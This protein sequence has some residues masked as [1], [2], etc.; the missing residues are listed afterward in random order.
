MAIIVHYCLPYMKCRLADKVLQFLPATMR[1]YLSDSVSDKSFKRP[2]HSKV[3]LTPCRKTTNSS[4]TGRGC[5]WRI[6]LGDDR[7]I[8]Q[9]AV[10][11]AGWS[12]GKGIFEPACS[13]A[14][15]LVCLEEC[16]SV[17]R[18]RQPFICQMFVSKCIFQFGWRSFRRHSEYKEGYVSTK[19]AQASAG[20]EIPSGLEDV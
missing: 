15:E 1:W 17:E 18:E 4:S 5:L 7:G 20:P 10:A 2:S 13:L 12:R 16:F 14:W 8:P 11:R 9:Y 6:S 19:G 3:S